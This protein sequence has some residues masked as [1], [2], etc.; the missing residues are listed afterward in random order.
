[1]P[2]F[3]FICLL[4]FLISG[5][6]ASAQTTL[7]DSRNPQKRRAFHAPHGAKSSKAK[8]GNVTHSAQFEFYKRVE[9]AAREKQW[10]LKKLS[11]PRFSDPRNFGHKRIPKRHP[12]HKMRYC[13]ECGIR[14]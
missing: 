6:H 9:K 14:H 1:M 2:I 12:S 13:Y 8:K 5:G 7:P 10:I 3:R 11:K 4:A